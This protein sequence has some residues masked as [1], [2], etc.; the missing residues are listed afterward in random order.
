ML[1]YLLK[2]LIPPHEV[3]SPK[4]TSQNHSLLP[5]TVFPVMFRASHGWALWT[6]G[7]QTN[8]LNWCSLTE[9]SMILEKLQNWVE[10]IKEE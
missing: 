7:Q 5:L 10:S 9:E 8:F 6:T 3:L 2:Y 1:C 4:I